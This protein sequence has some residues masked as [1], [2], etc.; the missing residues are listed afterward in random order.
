MASGFLPPSL[1][2]GSLLGNQ[3][4]QVRRRKPHGA[5]HKLVVF[6]KADPQINLGHRASPVQKQQE[7]MLRE[8][9][10]ALVWEEAGV[11]LSTSEP[12]PGRKPQTS[13]R[14]HPSSSRAAQSRPRKDMR[15][16]LPSEQLHKAETTNLLELTKHQAVTGIPHPRQTLNSGEG[17]FSV[18]KV[19]ELIDSHLPG[20]GKVWPTQSPELCLHSRC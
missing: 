17:H 16:V 18:L 5:V 20:T 14:S 8:A 13:P 3:E 1:C 7:T 4:K 10:C 2:S 12:R 15:T 11:Q 6:N 9:S 19:A